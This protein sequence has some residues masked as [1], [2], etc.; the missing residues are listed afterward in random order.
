MAATSTFMRGAAASAQQVSQARASLAINIP[1]TICGNEDATFRVQRPELLEDLPRAQV[2]SGAAVD[3]EDF[4]NLKGETVE[5]VPG[6]RL[7]AM[8]RMKGL[9]K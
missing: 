6:H 7:L 3:I 4:H 1:I 2:E 5:E 8:V 9:R